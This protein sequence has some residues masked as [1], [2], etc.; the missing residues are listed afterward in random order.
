MQ[1]PS[2]DDLSPLSELLCEFH[3]EAIAAT[4]QH[5][6]ESKH[7]CEVPGFFAVHVRSTLHDLLEPEGSNYGF[8]LDT[9]TGSLIIVYK[10][11]L[12]KE[13]KAYNGMIPRPGKESKARLRF[14]NHNGKLMSWPQRLPG[15]E[16]PAGVPD[17]ARIHF[18]SYYDLTSQNDLAWFKIACPLSVTSTGIA[19]LWNESVE[20]S[21][22]KPQPQK[23]LAEE[24]PDLHITLLKET[25][26][27]EDSDLDEDD[28]NVSGLS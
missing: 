11:F 3:H 4:K 13:Y 17:G 28:E 16:D 22:L 21:S 14:L 12:I 23:D 1:L 5:F 15:F 9:S 26:I 24:R 2:I 8:S 20:Y 19:C 7:R 6:V 25:I 27:D 10:N 18:I